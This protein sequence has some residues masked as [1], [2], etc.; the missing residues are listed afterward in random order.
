MNNN[1]TCLLLSVYLPCDN[2]SNVVNQ[3]VVEVIDCIENILNAFDF[4]A[5]IGL[6]LALLVEPM[7]NNG[8]IFMSS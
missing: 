5:F 4:N 8:L 7:L 2:L 6:S 3:Q 1:F